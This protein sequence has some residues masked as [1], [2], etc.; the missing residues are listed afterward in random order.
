M[1][2]HRFLLFG[3]TRNRP[4]GGWNDL[5]QTFPT[6]AQAKE[7]STSLLHDGTYVWYHTVDLETGSIIDR[8]VLGIPKL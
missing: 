3:G 4:D 8:G 1:K 5:I 7:G 6:S 2:P